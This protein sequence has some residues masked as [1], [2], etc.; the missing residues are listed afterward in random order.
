[1]KLLNR[2]IE[3]QKD[4]LA[5]PIKGHVVVLL[6]CIV[7]QQR[8]VFNA[9]VER[10]EKLTILVSTQMEPN[11]KFDTDWGSLN[12]VNQTNL[13]L[14]RKWKHHQAFTEDN[15]IHIPWRTASELR[16]LQPDVVVSYEMGIRTLFA[17]RYCRRRIPWVMVANM[18][19]HTEQCR[20]Q[21]RRW[22][23][24][25]ISRRAPVATYN[26]PSC[27]RYL[28]SLGFRN[29]QLF[30]FP[31]SADPDKIYFGEKK[32]RSGAIK[33]SFGGA[34]TERKNIV[35]FVRTLI[36]WCLA[37]PTF[38][39]ELT[40]AGTGPK[41]KELMGIDCPKTLSIKFLGHAT[42]TQLQSMYEHSDLY[43]YPSFAD[44]WGL[45]VEEAMASGLPTIA[46]QYVQSAETLI[47]H[48][49]NG[50]LFDPYAEYDLLRVLDQALRLSRERIDSMSR[51]ARAATRDYSPQIAADRLCEAIRG[52]LQ[53]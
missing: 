16:K 19:E 11:R 23:R 37:N 31:Y 50:W 26:G 25:Y 5:P 15:F 14:T 38:E 22:L 17:S 34:L 41:L 52:S 42:S 48:G 4:L 6:G 3:E 36:R 27:L 29:D 21:L 53:H 10:V 7:P 49:A 40:L 18:S 12:V 46:S 32:P 43:V 51:L 20:G 47:Q 30:H 8:H 45:G 2:N 1:M 39:L 9:L 24:K 33:L 28:K 13:M 35:G 44:E